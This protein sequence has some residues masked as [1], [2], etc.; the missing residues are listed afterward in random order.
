[1]ELIRKDIIISSLVKHNIPYEIITKYIL[2]YVGSQRI[3]FKPE[4]SAEIKKLEEQERIIRKKEEKRRRTA[5]HEINMAK[6]RLR[7]QL[8]YDDTERINNLVSRIINNFENNQSTIK[9]TYSCKGYLTHSSNKNLNSSE[10]DDYLINSFLELGGQL[11]YPKHIIKLLI[12][13]MIKRGFKANIEPENYLKYRSTVYV[14]PCYL[15]LVVK[16]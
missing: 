6:K 13:N 15:I 10:K 2:P 14:H 5:E 11:L 3:I 1:M 4:F 7:L 16:L 9:L 12:K 8:P